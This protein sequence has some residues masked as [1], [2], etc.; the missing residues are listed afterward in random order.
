[1]GHVIS[2][3]EAIF[4]HS[5]VSVE[6]QRENPSRWLD[7]RRHPGPAVSTNQRAHCQS[8][9]KKYWVSQQLQF[10]QQFL[11]VII[12][13]NALTVLVTQDVTRISLSLSRWFIDLSFLYQSLYTVILLYS[14]LRVFFFLLSSIIITPSSTVIYLS[15]HPLMSSPFFSS[16]ITSVPE[17][18]MVLLCVLCV[19]YIHIC[20]FVCVRVDLSD[21]STVSNTTTYIRQHKQ[22][23]VI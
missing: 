6:R 22:M 1:M 14:L 12:W 11:Y 20:V 23:S 7:L 15:L 19:L 16:S 18:Y 8:E 10:C 4:S 3:W 9:M 17:L 5:H 13:H 2:S 21:S